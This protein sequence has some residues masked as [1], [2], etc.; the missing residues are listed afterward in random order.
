MREGGRNEVLVVVVGAAAEPR[1]K[2]WMLSFLFRDEF[3]D[4][5]LKRAAQAVEQEGDPSRKCKR[6][7]GK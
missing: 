7:Q 6:E 2:V 4:G 3:R 1:V 5:P